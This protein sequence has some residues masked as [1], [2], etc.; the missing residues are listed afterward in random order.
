M[1]HDEKLGR[2]NAEKFRNEKIEN[3][4]TR[5]TGGEAPVLRKVRLESEKHREE[6]GAECAVY[7]S[8]PKKG[9]MLQLML[10][11]IGARRVL[12]VGCGLGYSAIWLARGLTRGGRVETVESD[13]IHVRLT[14]SNL[15]R[16]RVA[17]KVRVLQ[18]RA[19]D[20]LPILSK[21]YDL[22]FDD[23]AYGRPPA[24]L[25]DLTRL[26]K[27]GG[28]LVTS[29]WFTIEEA[30]VGEE[31]PWGYE[32]SKGMKDYA[33][34]LFP[35]RRFVSILLPHLWWGISLKISR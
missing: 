28:L 32:V 22:V 10:M 18:E 27:V 35:D 20:I 9:R 33:E 14:Q 12:E 2:T 11:T 5:L 1:V 8:S 30:I 23:A 4:L 25:E 6:H 16:A 34:K 26:T 21:P 13:P 17:G 31:G 7:P 19:E 15:K 3:Y 24:Y 29:N